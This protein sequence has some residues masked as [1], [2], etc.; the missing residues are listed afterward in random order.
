MEEEDPSFFLASGITFSSQM[1]R[2]GKKA[3]RGIQIHTRG[4]GIFC[5]T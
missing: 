4:E 1:Y 3:L 5:A 2:E